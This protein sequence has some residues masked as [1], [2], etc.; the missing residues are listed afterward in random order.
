MAV[1]K[2]SS[3]IAVYLSVAVCVSVHSGALDDSVGLLPG[4]I[5]VSGLALMSCHFLFR[6]VIRYNYN[7]EEEKTHAGNEGFHQIEE[8]WASTNTTAERY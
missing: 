5:R 6:L 3:T 1:S 4:V 2:P 7:K 8:T